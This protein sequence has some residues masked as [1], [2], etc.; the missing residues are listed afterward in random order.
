MPRNPD[1]ELVDP[2]AELSF[3]FSRSS[4]PGGQDVNKTSTRVTLRFDVEGSPSLTREQKDRLKARL[5]TRIDKRGTLSLAAQ[6][7]RTQAANRK[8]A[9]GRFNRLIRSAL[10]RR[11]PRKPTRAS[12]AAQERRLRKK[13]RR[14]QIKSDRSQAFSPEE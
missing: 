2:E 11:P 14:S 1:R 9:V 13:A 8:E 4:G 7:H 10:R 3:S 6:E 5:S 12:K